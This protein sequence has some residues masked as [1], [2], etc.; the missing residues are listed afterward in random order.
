VIYEYASIGA[1]ATAPARLFG[2]S[3]GAFSVRR[4]TNAL[5]RA[6]SCKRSREGGIPVLEEEM[7]KR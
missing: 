4:Q 1:V 3:A 7:R 2:R 6:F 5:W